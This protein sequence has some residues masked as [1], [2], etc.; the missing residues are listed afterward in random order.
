MSGEP[1]TPAEQVS[2][3]LRSNLER[4]GREL[5]ETAKAVE[6]AGGD[7]ARRL[8]STVDRACGERERVLSALDGL[9]TQRG[10]SWDLLERD[11]EREARQLEA[12][13]ALVRADLDAHLPTPSLE[14]DWP[15]SSNRSDAS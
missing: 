5:E 14:V 13:V 3:R 6:R 9:E 15:G 8:Q 10:V 11:L 12:E 2:D 1:I 7:V 4:I